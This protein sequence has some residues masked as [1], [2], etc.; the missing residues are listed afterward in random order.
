V[1]RG[2]VKSQESAGKT[3]FV[4]ELGGVGGVARFIGKIEGFKSAN[5]MAE[6]AELPGLGSRRSEVKVATTGSN[7]RLRDR[8][9]KSTGSANASVVEEPPGVQLLVGTWPFGSWATG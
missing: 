8:W 2:R 9:C 3:M 6:L 1:N 4:K 5:H 7:F